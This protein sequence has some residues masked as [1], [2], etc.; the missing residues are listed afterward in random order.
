MEINRAKSADLS[1]LDETANTDTFRFS[2]IRFKSLGIV[3]D[4]FR[5]PNL[6]FRVWKMYKV[7]LKLSTNKPAVFDSARLN[8]GGFE[9]M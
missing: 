8:F 1:R 2:I 3:S 5:L 4:H 6:N 7:F 9:R